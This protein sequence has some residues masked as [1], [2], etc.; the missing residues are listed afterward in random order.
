MTSSLSSSD[1]E[2]LANFRYAIRKFHR[3]SKE[4]LAEK[5]DLTPEQYETLL[6]L[7]A[8]STKDG[9]SVGDLSERLQIRP[10]TAVSLTNKLM[11]RG[12]VTKGHARADHRIVCVK[13][14][15]QGSKLLKPLALRHRHE[16]RSRSLEMIDALLRLKH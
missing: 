6:A 11:A 9:L 3:F 13:L 2:A 14:T 7:K 10:H 5:A 8:R 12:L 15:R 1:Y 16:I 4:I